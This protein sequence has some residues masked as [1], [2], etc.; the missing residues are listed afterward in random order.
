MR[1]ALLNLATEPIETV[2]RRRRLTA[3][4]GVVVLAVSLAHA[5]AIW[6]LQRQADAVAAAD[7]T[8]AVDT[9]TM[10][11]WQQEVAE[12]VAVGDM[13]RARGVI[14]AVELG[15]QLIA[16]RTIP[17]SAIFTDLEELLPD[18]VRL[19]SVQPGVD[20]VDQVRISMQ[21]VAADTGPLQDLLI[22]LE[23]HAHFADV[24]PQRE[25]ASDD[26]MSRLLLVARYLPASQ[27]V[28]QTVSPPG[29]QP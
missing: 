28:S 18:G 6:W 11:A 13:D 29:S 14:G 15:N 4:A 2:R 8:P 26:G 27:T 24:F 5:G 16:W 25:E 17:W 21:A 12:I 3:I 1:G 10:R 22:R 20:A 7:A 9:E 19:E 23:G